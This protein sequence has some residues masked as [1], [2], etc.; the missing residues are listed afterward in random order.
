[1]TDDIKGLT[2][3]Q[4]AAAV[5]HPHTMP[6]HRAEV[7]QEIARRGAVKDA[8]WDMV[9]EAWHNN[10]EECGTCGFYD[11]EYYSDTGWYSSCRLLDMDGGNPALCDAI[12]RIKEEMEDE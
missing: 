6:K 1:M 2:D 10:A 3:A 9:G 5:D 7:E 12:D 11:T 8:E 4:L